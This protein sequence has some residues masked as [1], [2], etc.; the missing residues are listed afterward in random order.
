[1]RYLYL[2]LLCVVY[3]CGGQADYRSYS[4][5]APAQVK[6][7]MPEV[8]M[9]HA[10]YA[11]NDSL[12]LLLKFEDV[13]QVLDILQAASSYEY[14][15]RNGLSGRDAAVLQDSID[16][17]NRKITDIEGELHVQ[18]SLPGN[19]VQEPN[20]LHLRVWQVLSGQERMGV[21]FKVP[22]SSGMMQKN[23]LLVKE[24]TAKPMLQDYITTSDRLLMRTYANTDSAIPVDRFE[25]DFMPAAP[26]MSMKK[27]AVARTL[28]VAETDTLSASDTLSFEQEGLYLFNP[29]SA[30]ARGVVV[31][32]GKYPLIT[33]A[34]ELVPPLIYLTTSEERDALFKAAD[35]KAA[36]DE[37]WLEVGGNESRAR[38]LIRTYY[39]RVEMANK[40][41]T[42]HKAGWATD[43]GMI[44]IIYGR[45]S[46]VSQ[47]GPNITWIYRESDTSPYIKFVFTK[48]ENNFTE[49]YYELVRRRE[50]E[51]SWY[52]SVAKWRA[53]KTNL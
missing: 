15:V 45:P 42:A 25:L 40:L 19:V 47:I 31:L 27:P 4:T 21:E 11:S 6:R 43:R 8:V 2:L 30:L 14:A 13:R 16:L 44:Y 23:Y 24:G 9:Q 22:L 7:E 48:K 18:L 1:M 20:V 5:P 34:E 51:E 39:K 3:G 10:Y 46:S 50:Y 37:F 53:G 52:S 38:E 36:V 35:P 33:R 32:S 26:P 41:F 29:G 49:N 28:A 17:P 12:H